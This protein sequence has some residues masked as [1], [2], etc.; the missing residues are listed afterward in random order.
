MGWEVVFAEP[1]ESK[2]AKRYSTQLKQQITPGETQTLVKEIHIKPEESTR[3]LSSGTRRV[4][5]T[6]VEYADGSV[7]RADEERKQ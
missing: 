1:D 3:H 4:R 5:L 6:R 7:W 2:G